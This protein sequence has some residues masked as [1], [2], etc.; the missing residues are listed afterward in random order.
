[1][2]NR[3][4]EKQDSWLPMTILAKNFSYSFKKFIKPKRE[5]KNNF[6]LPFI[7]AIQDGCAM[8]ANISL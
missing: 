8:A 1:M 7:L 4:S 5:N 3:F 2:Q 6:A